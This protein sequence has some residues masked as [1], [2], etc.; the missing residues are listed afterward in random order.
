MTAQ[1]IRKMIADFSNEHGI[2]TPLPETMEVDPETYANVCQ[3][4]F[5]QKAPQDL[6][7]SQRVITIGIGKHNGIFFKGVEIILKRQE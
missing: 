2:E 5:D 3:A 1:D 6:A 4:I 7:T